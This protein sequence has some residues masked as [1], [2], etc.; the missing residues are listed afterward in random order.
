EF[1][2]LNRPFQDRKPNPK[3]I[4]PARQPGER[5]GLACS[6]P[7]SD[8]LSVSPGVACVACVACAKKIGPFL[9]LNEAGAQ[10]NDRSATAHP[11]FCKALL[12]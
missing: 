1:S 6:A 12:G 2:T 7:A 3:Q 4:K 8:G 11:A 5:S 10:P 9:I